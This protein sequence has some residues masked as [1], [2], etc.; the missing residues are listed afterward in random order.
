MPAEPD[1]LIEDESE[2]LA[3][4]IR[5]IDP[6]GASMIAAPSQAMALIIG[7]ARDPDHVVAPIAHSSHSL[8]QDDALVLVAHNRQAIAREE[9]R[10]SKVRALV[11]LPMARD[12]AAGQQAEEEGDDDSPLAVPPAPRA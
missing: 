8:G 6:I 1:P 3:D 4:E 12:G 2:L 10:E 7:R 9:T 11:P 5:G